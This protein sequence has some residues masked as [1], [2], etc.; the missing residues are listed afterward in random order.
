MYDKGRYFTVTGDHLPG[1][2][3]TIE[4]RDVTELQSGIERLDPAHKKPPVSVTSVC[5]ATSKFEALMAG[6]WEPLYRSQSEADLALCGFLARQHRCDPCKINEEFRKSGLYRDKWERE[7]YRNET[8]DKAIKSAAPASAPARAC[9]PVEATKNWREAF[10]SY[11]Q[12]EQGEAKFLIKDFLP[13][14]ITFIGGK[15]GSGKTWLALAIAEAVVTQKPFLGIY[16]VPSSVPVLYLTPE[17][18]D[19]PFRSRLNKVRLDTVGDK[20]LCR[21]LS[22]GAFKLDD[23][24]L[25]AAVEELKPL[26]V[27][28]TVTRFSTAEDENRSADIREFAN[29]L[30]ELSRHAAGIIGVHHSLKHREKPNLDNTLRGTGDYAALCDA[31]W[32]VECQ[33]PETLLMQLECVKARE[34]EQPKPFRV[35]RKPEAYPWEFVAIDEF[36]S[37]EDDP[38]GKERE[39]GKK[40]FEA[41]VSEHPEA[42][43]RTIERDLGIRQNKIGSQAELWGWRK[44]RQAKQWERVSDTGVLALVPVPHSKSVGEQKQGTSSKAHLLCPESRHLQARACEREDC[45]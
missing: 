1:T 35:M 21:T 19:R 7:D 10:K 33:N 32:S 40:Q 4:K 45:A 24:I 11:D 34:F 18:G 25:I 42:D 22:D 6:Q 27:L 43:Y 28:D 31:V 2:R 41:Y 23:A 8:I 37:D 3:T 16:E 38:F 44:P 12:L 17:V 36:V 13:A 14:G 30:L 5:S 20:F 9:E 39:C 29:T 15:P 26:V